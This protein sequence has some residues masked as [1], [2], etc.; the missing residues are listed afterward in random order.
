MVGGGGE[1]FAR[2]EKLRRVGEGGENCARLENFD[3]LGEVVVLVVQTRFLVV[4]MITMLVITLLL[5]L[6]GQV[7][8]FYVNLHLR[9]I[10]LPQMGVLIVHISFVVVVVIP[11][12]VLAW[13]KGGWNSF[14]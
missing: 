2:L 9:L 13:F 6:L 1:H 14:N 10:V 3:G 8:L 5:W 11:M 4:I 12:L 7:Q